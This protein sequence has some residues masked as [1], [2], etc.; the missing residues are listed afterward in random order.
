MKTIHLTFFKKLAN[1]SVLEKK[2]SL[3]GKSPA[4]WTNQSYARAIY[5]ACAYQNLNLQSSNEAKVKHR[6]SRE[7]I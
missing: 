5:N 4:L 7:Q 6:E 3:R 1:K 2:G